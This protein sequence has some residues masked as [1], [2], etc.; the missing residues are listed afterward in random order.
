M[1][2]K[3]LWKKLTKRYRI[4]VGWKNTETIFT[5]KGFDDYALCIEY[6][7]EQVNKGQY[8]Y[9]IDNNGKLFRQLA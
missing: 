9:V 5:V 3:K 1:V 7:K 8:K 6:F 4:V 2:I